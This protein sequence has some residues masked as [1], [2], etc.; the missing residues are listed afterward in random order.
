MN[1]RTRRVYAWEPDDGDG[2]VFLV[3]RLWPRGV[4]KEEL[5]DVTWMREVAPSDELRQWFGHDP[6]RWPDFRE[7]YHAELRENADVWKPLAQAAQ[8]GPIILLYAAK[9]EE[10]NNAVALKDFLHAQLGR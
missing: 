9:D 8:K 2:Q 7:R 5:A 3:D 4:S 1:I 10:H 6:E